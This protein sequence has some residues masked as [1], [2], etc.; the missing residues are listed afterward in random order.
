[1]LW[2]LC[3]SSYSTSLGG[4]SYLT[5]NL[6]QHNSFHLT[7]ARLSR[8]LPGT[9]LNCP[10]HTRLLMEISHFSFASHPGM[11]HLFQQ[12]PSKKSIIPTSMPRRLSRHSFPPSRCISTFPLLEETRTVCHVVIAFCSYKY[13]PI[14]YPH[15][16]GNTPSV[17][18]SSPL[19]L[20]PTEPQYRTCI[21]DRTTTANIDMHTKIDLRQ[22]PMLDRNRLRDL[23]FCL[24]HNS[25]RLEW[26][27]IIITDRHQNRSASRRF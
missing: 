20:T 25:V 6:D 24:N 4:S 15:I 22:A 23:C 18:N 8:P 12:H 27:H 1:M 7:A 13:W 14:L 16:S 19:P 11:N 2:R 9:P 21:C 10:H 3:E 5:L 17:G 26:N